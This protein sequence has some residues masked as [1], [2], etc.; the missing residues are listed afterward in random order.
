MAY[1]ADLHIHS[2]YSR[3]CSPQLNIPNLVEWAKYKGINVLGT[4]DF[5]H[6][7][8]LA[9]LKH[10][11]TEDESGFLTHKDS[12]V[13][14]VLTVE[15]ASIYS[16]KGRGRRVHNLVFLPDFASADTFQ[17]SLLAR[18]A[19]LGSDGRPIVGISS[20]DLL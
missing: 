5:L 13:K 16:Q 15:I 18:K 19:N 20:K 12:D 11:L 3:A 14:F 6:P 10:N 17:K 2:R 4:G 8:W 9:E 7:L 1:V